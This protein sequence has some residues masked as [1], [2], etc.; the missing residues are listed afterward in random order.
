MVVFG[1]ISILSLH[2]PAVLLSITVHFQPV[3]WSM[4]CY[5]IVHCVQFPDTEMC[6]TVLTQ[7]QPDSPLHE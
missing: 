2:S 6:R 3:S 5:N 4:T 1:E 7:H